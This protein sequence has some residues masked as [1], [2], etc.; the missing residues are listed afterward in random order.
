ML[1]ELHPLM[2]T[3][4]Y[5]NT[6]VIGTHRPLEQQVSRFRKMLAPDRDSIPA[7]VSWQS[8]GVEYC[9]EPANDVA[10]LGLVLR[11]G[12]RAPTS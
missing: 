1:I 9:L 12:H 10:D 11:V 7:E 5:Q 6:D 4:A 2:I 3:D 8:S